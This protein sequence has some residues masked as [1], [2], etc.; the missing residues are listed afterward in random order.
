MPSAAAGCCGC[1]WR[2]GR[3][4]RLPNGKRVRPV[5]RAGARCRC[6][7][8]VVFRTGRLVRRA[9]R[10][11]R[12]ARRPPQ[13]QRLP[14]VRSSCSRRCRKEAMACCPST[15][16]AGQP[17][18]AGET[19]S[20]STSSVTSYGNSMP[21]QKLEIGSRKHELPTEHW[22]ARPVSLW[23]SRCRAIVCSIVSPACPPRTAALA[24][25]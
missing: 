1:R 25:Y 21:S 22:H 13:R 6:G 15:C 18:S 9:V 20:A 5:A 17:V 11:Q 3:H 23:R 10:H 8:P 7:H 14:K 24:S 12:N 16:G 19:A 4:C 2:S